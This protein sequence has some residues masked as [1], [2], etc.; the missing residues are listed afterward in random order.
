M[1]GAVAFLPPHSDSSRGRNPHLRHHVETLQFRG[2]GEPLVKTNEGERRTQ[3]FLHQHRGGKLTRIRG[4]QG[5]PCQQQVS[6]R[7]NGEDVRY[8]IPMGGQ[9]IELSEQVSPLQARQHPFTCPS[10]NRAEDLGSCPSPGDDPVV[11]RQSITCPAAIGFR[12]D[13]RYQRRCI[14]VPHNRSLRSS[15]SASEM[16]TGNT[17]RGS[18]RIAA[19]PPRPGLITPWL[20]SRS[21]APWSSPAAVATSFATGLPRSRTWTSPPRR[22][23]RT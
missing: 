16:L 4:A 14:P 9:A 6:S 15:A 21:R 20:I 22:T 7:S 11:F 10:F 8:L 2:D 23:S 18:S 12:N 3:L 1:V 17:S 19:A 13:Q 5:M